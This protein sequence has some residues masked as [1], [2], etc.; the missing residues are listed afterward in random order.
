MAKPDASVSCTLARDK[1]QSGFFDDCFGNIFAMFAASVADVLGFE[2]VA[3]L[4]QLSL[5]HI[6]C[7]V[8]ENAES[9]L[10]AILP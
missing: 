10:I 7:V 8:I 6:R 3:F 5:L 4:W 1:L 2:R 9:I